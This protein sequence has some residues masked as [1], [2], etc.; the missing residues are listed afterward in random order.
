[1]NI[2]FNLLN[3]MPLDLLNVPS[4][5]FVS[6]VNN[7]SR[8]SNKPNQRKIHKLARQTGRKVKG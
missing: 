6:F 2:L 8:H 1:M 7:P 5:S 4:V 3:N